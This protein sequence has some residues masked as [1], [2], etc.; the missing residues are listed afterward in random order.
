MTPSVVRQ[1]RHPQREA[2]AVRIEDPMASMQVAEPPRPSVGRRVR[3]AL[4]RRGP[5]L[6]GLASVLVL[7]L[8]WELAS[9]AELVDP[10][11][12]SRPSEI[13]A[14]GYEMFRTGEIYPHLWVSAKEAFLGFVAAVAVGIPTGLLIG[15]FGPLR[16]IAEPYIVAMY[17]T[18]TVAFLPL[19]ILW[20]GIGLSSKVFLIFLGGVFMVLVNTS[21]GVLSVDPNRIETARSFMASEWRIF[22]EV[23]LPSTVGYIT[24]G[25]RLAIGRVLITMFV[26]EL[27][28]ANAG[29]GFLITQAGMQFRTAELFVGIFIL[30]GTGVALSQSLRWVEDHKLARFR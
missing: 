6:L 22:V 2:L 11:F 12:I 4:W 30:A 20:L 16:A 15:R 19:L 8:V 17:S 9:R 24:A 28:V 1:S 25:I 10:F 21:A 27:Y 5:S 23:I 3:L 18:P 26:A 13:A 29:V 14:V 7:G